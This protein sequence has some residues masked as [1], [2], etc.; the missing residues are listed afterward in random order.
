MPV[1]LGAY[2][3][4]EPGDEGQDPAAVARPVRRRQGH[5]RLHRPQPESRGQDRG[6]QAGNALGLPEAGEPRQRDSRPRHGA[7][8]PRA[9]RAGGGFGHGA[10]LARRGAARPA[11]RQPRPQHPAG[12]KGGGHPDGLPL[13]GQPP[14]D[15]QRLLAP[16]VRSQG[17][18]R[19]APVPDRHGQA[20]AAAPVPGPRVQPRGDVGQL[21]VLRPQDRAGVRRGGGE[22]GRAP[23][24]PA[25][26]E[27]MGGV[28]RLFHD[29]EGHLRALEIGGSEMWGINM[30]LGN[31]QA[32]GIDLHH[33]IRSLGGEKIFMGHV[34]GR[35]RHRP[36]FRGDLPR[37]RRLRPPRRRPLPQPR[38]LRGPSGAGALA[39]RRRGRGLPPGQRLR[40]GGTCGRS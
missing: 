3:R 25:G 5:R 35:R 16:F 9:G 19:R 38:R 7:G 8:H 2:A 20:R 14:D 10:H 1:C 29:L 40:P 32:M 26:G 21:R 27:S 13:D 34:Q 17:P 36:G 39:P 18:R 37:P 31:W 30:C 11:D 24:R 12:G 15:D 33:A 23:G 4:F 28:P 22:D 6:Q